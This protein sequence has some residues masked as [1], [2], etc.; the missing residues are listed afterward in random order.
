MTSASS[1]HSSGL[2]VRPYIHG[3]VFLSLPDVPYPRFDPKDVARIP[4]DTWE[5][6]QTPAGVRLEFTGG[7]K[8]VEIEYV[9]RATDPGY[10]GDAG[11]ITFG[12]WR[13]GRPIDEQP[14][15][16]GRHHLRLAVA[17]DVADP[18]ERVTVYLPEGLRPE[19]ISLSGIGGDILPASAQPRWLAYGDSITEGW[20]A[21]GPAFSWVMHVSR[22]FELDAVNLGY[23]GAARGEIPCAEAMA[24]VSADVISIAYGTN[25]WSRTVHSTSMVE[26]GFNAFLTLLRVGHPD[27]PVVVISPFVRPEAEQTP[28]SLG[29][30]LSAMRQAM[31][32]VVHDRC[33]GGDTRL[34]LV[35][36]LEVIE[37]V[38]LVDGV[39]PGDQGH[40]RAAA[41]IGPILR[42][43]LPVD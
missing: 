11:G 13:Q 41:V 37:A 19:I 43:A 25:C 6:A 12:A 1:D 21:S 24:G 16:H 42:K 17:D 26:S 40:R 29:S 9:T 5:T 15:Q 10:R 22:D 4:A 31:E 2:D 3:C 34:E 38:D 32:H 36:G 39:H 27:T 28:N 7:A 35:P 23:A 18:E 30:T 20:S 14:A 33:A 8:A